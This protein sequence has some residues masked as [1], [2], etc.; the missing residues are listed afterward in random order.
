M[1]DIKIINKGE[2]FFTED[3]HELFTIEEVV[4]KTKRSRQTIYNW[5]KDGK[6]FRIDVKGRPWFY[7]KD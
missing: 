7:F 6:I 3:N 1:S 2:S 4:K 5:V